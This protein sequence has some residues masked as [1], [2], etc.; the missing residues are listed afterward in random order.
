M[1]H[2]D[3]P[4]NPFFLSPSPNH[5]SNLAQS[6]E[7]FSLL[8]KPHCGGAICSAKKPPGTRTQHPTSVCP[9]FL[10]FYTRF[11]PAVAGLPA[12]GWV[13]VCAVLL[14]SGTP[15]PE[16][17]VTLEPGFSDKLLINS[18]HLQPRSAVAALW[19]RR[20]LAWAAHAAGCEA[21]GGKSTCFSQTR[22]LQKGGTF[23]LCEL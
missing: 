22:K 9:P 14:L 23:V 20:V 1:L 3:F 18:R 12:S 10:P 17:G 8:Q 19:G 2:L 6:P 13:P 15:R 4:P 21:A 16:S 11:A 5:L 7:W